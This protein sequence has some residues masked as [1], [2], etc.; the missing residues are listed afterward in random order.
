MKTDVKA[1]LEEMANEAIVAQV[2]EHNNGFNATPAIDAFEMFA[3]AVGFDVCWPGLC[4]LV[5][6]KNEDGPWI[7]IGSIS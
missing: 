1:K 2:E 6:E 7:E 5:C 3:R 4:P